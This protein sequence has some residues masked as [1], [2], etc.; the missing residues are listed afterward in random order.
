MN[1]NYEFVQTKFSFTKF[2]LPISK[3]RRKYVT[4]YMYVYKGTYLYSCII[5]LCNKTFCKSFTT[6]PNRTVALIFR[7]PIMLSL[8]VYEFVPYI[9]YI[10]A[11]ID[12]FIWV[13]NVE[14]ILHLQFS[15]KFQ[16]FEVFARSLYYPKYV[17]NL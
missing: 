16:V 13:V 5:Y 17:C 7:V 15:Q 9:R 14:F 8:L 12:I 11:N 10:Y 3:K 2:S 1:D 4:L 6:E